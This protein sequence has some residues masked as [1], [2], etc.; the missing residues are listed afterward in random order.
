M[1]LLVRPPCE[2]VPFSACQNYRA[3]TYGICILRTP[4]RLSSRS[5][6]HCH[7]QRR[8]SGEAETRRAGKLRLRSA[9]IGVAIQCNLQYRPP[10][11]W[12]DQMPRQMHA[13][14]CRGDGTPPP[15]NFPHFHLPSIPPY[16]QP[17][18]LTC[19]LLHFAR[20]SQHINFTA[21]WYRSFTG[22]HGAAAGALQAARGMGSAV[23]L[24]CQH[25]GRGAPQCLL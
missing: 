24:G 23:L 5:V 18:L 11:R 4:V 25:T 22:G 7:R 10:T 2:G 12:Q 16:P 3:P 14:A 21:F 17:A 9:A 20:S 6:T 13:I 1:P 19:R 15:H 8:G